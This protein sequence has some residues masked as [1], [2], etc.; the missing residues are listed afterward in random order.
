[1]GACHRLGG[2]YR[3]ALLALLLLAAVPAAAQ[4]ISVTAP[5]TLDQQGAT[6]VLD[7]DVSAPGTAFYL[8][9]RGITFDLNGHTVTYNTEASATPVYGISVGSPS[10]WVNMDESGM[11]IRN[12]TVVQGA[13]ASLH[14]DAVY[15]HYTN[16]RNLEIS[17]LHLTVSGSSCHGIT[18]DWGRTFDVHDNTITSN[19]SQIVNRYAYDGYAMYFKAVTDSSIHDNVVAGGHGG[20]ATVTCINTTISGNDISHR[21][22]DTNGYGILLWAPSGLQVYQNHIHTPDGVGLLVDGPYGNTAI[23]ANT[24]DVQMGPKPEYGYGYTAWGIKC[25]TYPNQN[26]LGGLDLHDNIIH[27]TTG[28]GLV[29]AAG[30]GIYDSHP[31]L[32]NRYYHNDITAVTTDSTKE[33]VGIRLAG[34]KAA[35]TGTRIYENTV[36]SNSANLDLTSADGAG[37]D[38]IVF[39]SNTLVRGANP[40]GYHTITIGYWTYATEHTVFLDTRVTGGASVEDV[41]FDAASGG[42]AYSYSVQ[43]YLTVTA[44]DALGNPVAGA[45]VTAAPQPGG[46]EVTGTTDDQ[47]VAKL[48]LTQYFR[49]GVTYPVTSSYLYHTPHTVRVHKEGYQDVVQEVTMDASKAVEATLLPPGGTTAGVELAETVDSDSPVPGE[50]VT[51]TIAF[52]NPGPDPLTAVV[53]VGSVPAEVQYVPG[54]ARLGGV[55]VSPDPYSA[56]QIAVPVGTLGPGAEGVV[57]YQAVVR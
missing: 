47:G 57:T 35:D 40:I 30:I 11:R 6:Y 41:G 56:G 12:G 17:G 28:A 54:S 16:P 53:I 19:V 2:I 3:A 24:I 18:V 31:D 50:V 52:T 29:Q 42:A 10:A 55:T 32:N 48:A 14:S 34:I 1:M 39:A 46:E 44:H 38:G 22:V 33:A 37:P 26:P 7:Q 20:I 49:S 51:Y 5:G 21:A 43:W 13:G 45:S 8:T 25:R 36:T 15:V 23:Y 27:A 4:T 9:A